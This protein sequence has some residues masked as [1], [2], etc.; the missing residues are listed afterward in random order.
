VRAGIVAAQGDDDLAG[1]ID[2]DGGDG[3]T[4]GLAAVDRR[5]RDRLGSFGSSGD[6]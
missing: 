3:V 6:Q 2:D 5:F 4:I 1:A